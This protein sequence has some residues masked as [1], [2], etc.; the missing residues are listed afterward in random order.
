MSKIEDASKSA[1]VLQ[2]NELDA[3]SGGL[4]FCKSGFIIDWQPASSPTATHPEYKPTESV[5]LLP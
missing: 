3:A 1:S 2:N 4:N 5:K